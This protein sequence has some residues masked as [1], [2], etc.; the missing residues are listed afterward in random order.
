MAVRYHG[1]TFAVAA[2]TVPFTADATIY[3]W[4][5]IVTATATVTLTGANSVLMATLAANT[6]FHMG[7]TD[8]VSGEPIQLS[9]Y[10]ATG[11]ATVFVAYA[12][13]AV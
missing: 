6:P 8:P 2:S 11:T 7:G 4:D 3:G 13:R 9:L 12:T 10:S 1:I 5:V